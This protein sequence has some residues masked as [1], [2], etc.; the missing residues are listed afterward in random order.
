MIVVQTRPSL[1]S[2]VDYWVCHISVFCSHGFSGIAMVFHGP[3]VQRS[4]IRNRCGQGSGYETVQ[5]SLDEV[6]DT[7]GC[8]TL[9]GSSLMGMLS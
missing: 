6:G 5:V 9:P 2:S 3:S 1:N 4:R 7:D 8:H